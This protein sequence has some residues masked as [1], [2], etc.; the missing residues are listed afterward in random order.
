M[1]TIDLLN[2]TDSIRRALDTLWGAW[3]TTQAAAAGVALTSRQPTIAGLAT[4]ADAEALVAHLSAQP[5][6]I[7]RVFL[8]QDRPCVSVDA[9]EVAGA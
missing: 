9:A 4:H 7:A 6:I 5:G 8:S 3:W 2:H 1:N